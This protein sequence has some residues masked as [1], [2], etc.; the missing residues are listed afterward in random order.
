MNRRLA[1]ALTVLLAACGEA[2]VV[3][4]TPGAIE[5]EG[6]GLTTSLLVDEDGLRLAGASAD[7]SKV[8]V[9]KKEEEDGR[10]SARVVDLVAKKVLMT[11]PLGAFCGSFDPQPTFGPGAQ[12]LAGWSFEPSARIWELLTWSAADPAN[13]FVL[14][15]SSGPDL[16]NEITLLVFTPDEERLVYVQPGP[17]GDGYRLMVHDFASGQAA[18]AAADASLVAPR[19]SP[20]GSRMVFFADGMGARTVVSYEFATGLATELGRGHDWTLTPSSDGS[21]LAFRTACTDGATG[22]TACE[23][24]DW[25]FDSQAARLVA[26]NVESFGGYT[27]SGDR[28]AYVSGGAL[29]VTTLSTSKTFTAAASACW[30]RLSPDGTKLAWLATCAADSKGNASGTLKLGTLAATSVTGAKTVQS[31]ALL[32]TLTTEPAFAPD[33]KRLLFDRASY[34]SGFDLYFYDAASSYSYP[35]S[36][37]GNDLGAWDGQSGSRV[38]SP[39]GKTVVYEKTTTWYSPYCPWGSCGYRELRSRDITSSWGSDRSVAGA[40][41]LSGSYGGLMASP[42]AKS[43][44]GQHLVYLLTNAAGTGKLY[45]VN[46]STSATTQLGSA[47][48]G[49]PELSVAL[50]DSFAALVNGKGLTLLTGL[51]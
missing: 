18:Q 36:I 3:E 38:V 46:T 30:A 15:R 39:D 27:P 50:G 51:K 11:G 24:R 23:L 31:G 7:R 33:G 14:A 1:I 6:S 21:R 17:V 13:I 29:K 42:F 9:C 35:R 32:G 43:P 10:G 25:G 41:S 49:S 12:R 44:K 2:T 4:E 8:L 40:T 22:Q 5:T 45:A 48:G 28:V 19:L 34:T 20:D 26:T 16:N 47:E 37:V